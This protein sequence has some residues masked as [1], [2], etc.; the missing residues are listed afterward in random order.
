[1]QINGRRFSPGL[2]PTIATILILSLL[3]SLGLWQLDRAEQKSTIYQEFTKRREQPPVNLNNEHELRDNKTGMLWRHITLSG[4]F[5]SAM[6]ILLDNQMLHGN[7]GYLVYTPFKLDGEDVLVLVNRGWIAGSGNRDQIPA[8]D[9]PPGRVEIRAV[10]KD[11]PA[12][13]ILLDEKNIVETIA[14]GIYRAQRIDINEIEQL[15][16]HELLPYI[17]RLEPDSGHGFA[18]H[19]QLPGSGEEKHLG[20]AFQW[21]ALAATLVIIYFAVNIKKAT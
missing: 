7:A 20:Y 15:V 4:E 12:T 16:K 14:Y 3:V 8:I 6:N 18:R 11:V 1:M 17:A 21:F 19:W 5:I 13:G 2:V 10:A 9:T